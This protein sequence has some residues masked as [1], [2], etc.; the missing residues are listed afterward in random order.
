[1]VFGVA[2]HVTVVYGPLPTGSEP[3]ISPLTV[4]IFD[5]LLSH[6]FTVQRCPCESIATPTG[7]FRY[8]IDSGNSA[9]VSASIAVTYWFVPHVRRAARRPLH[10]SQTSSSE[11]RRTATPRI[12]SPVGICLP[13]LFHGIEPGEPLVA[14]PVATRLIEGVD[15][16]PI[17][18]TGLFTSSHPSLGDFEVLR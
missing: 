15:S 5:A 7:P 8:H 4:S 16:E 3:I 14:H 2:C 11:L 17:I 12:A 13:G 9:P 18:P 6:W 1:M 10:R